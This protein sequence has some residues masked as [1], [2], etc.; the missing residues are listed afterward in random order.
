[1]VDTVNQLRMVR[2]LPAVLPC[3][4]VRRHR[5]RRPRPPMFVPFSVMSRDH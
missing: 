2:M 1:M 3:R 4:R 5:Q